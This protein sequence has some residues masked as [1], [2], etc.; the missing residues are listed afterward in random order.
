[1]CFNSRR[2]SCGCRTTYKF[3]ERV[4][5]KNNVLFH[6][7]IYSNAETF[8]KDYKLDVDIVF[9]D[10]ELPDMNGMEAAAEVFCRRRIFCGKQVRLVGIDLIYP[11]CYNY[12][13][14]I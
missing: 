9:M 4:F 11:R 12:I 7:V 8:L 5:P 3:F 2:R 14:K 13:V 6:S 1:M 10:I